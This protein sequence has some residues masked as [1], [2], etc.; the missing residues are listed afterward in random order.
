MSHADGTAASTTVTTGVEASLD[1]PVGRIVLDRPRSLNALT[2]PMVQ[3]LERVL[4]AW[5]DEPL[6]AITISST[7]ERAFCAGGDIRQVR[8]NTLDGAESA[9]LEFFATEY[10]V[11]HLL[12]A[13]RAPVVA[14]VD[15]ICMG[16]GLGLSVHG[17]FRVV[18][19]AAVLAMPETSIGFFPDVGATHFLPRLPGEIGT[20][21]GLTGARVSAADAVGIGL[22]THHVPS[23]GLGAV[24][25]RLAADDRPVELVLAELTTAAGESEL[26]AR[27][28]QIDRTFDADSVDAILDALRGEGT[29]WADATIEV[30][31]SASRQSL[32]LTLDLLRRG[33]DLSLREC[34]DLELRAAEGA[35]RTPDFVEG[36]RAVL[37]DKDRAPQW[38]QSRYQGMTAE[39]H[40]VWSGAPAVP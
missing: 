16:G 21:L 22:A 35:M 17:A 18:G 11:N 5:V 9:S 1:G 20:Y 4:L 29:A 23:A 7:S 30:L 40:A 31:E 8:Q 36:V 10:R 24:A 15:G 28:A 32:D 33:A 39:G 38:G 25:D 2:L 34:L 6:R 19:D 27:R 13:S 14:L 3:E 26:V 12:A 37:V